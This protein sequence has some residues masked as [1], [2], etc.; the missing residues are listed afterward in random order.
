[1]QGRVKL[2]PHGLNP[3][4]IFQP[5]N[6]IDID[7]YSE[8]T[9]YKIIYVSTID[10][11]KHQ[12]KVIEA[13]Y[14]LRQKGL[15]IVLHIVGPYYPKSFRKLKKTMQHFDIDEKWIFYR[16]SAPFSVLHNLYSEADM[17]LFAS[18][19]ENMP[20]ILIEKMASGLPIACSNRGPMPEILRDGGLYF[21]PE[22]P[23]DIGN[24]VLKL[25]NSP[26]LRQELSKKSF[27]YSHEYSWHKCAKETLIFLREIASVA[28]K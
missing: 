19:C 12:W 1:M 15:P 3:R 8:A 18:S 28:N 14:T 27:E 23:E 4:F 6:Q 17:G 22:R 26:N 11:Y 10:Q 13:L 2:I 9:P 25:I 7:K 20:N 21:D 16:G 24:V 5:K